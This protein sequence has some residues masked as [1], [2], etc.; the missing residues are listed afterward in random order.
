[1]SGKGLKAVA[2][3][4]TSSKTNVGPDK[5][6]DKRQLAAINRYAKR[7]GYEI[8]DIFYDAAVSGADPINERPAFAHM[9]ERLLGNGARTIIVESPDRFARDLIQQ[10]LGH[11][12]LKARGIALIAASSPQHFLE[13]T[14]TAVLIRQVLGGVAEFEKTTLV[15]KLKAARDRKR[16]ATGKCGGRKTHL[17]RRPDVV[18]LAKSLA[19]KKSKGGQLSLR[20]ISA[21]RAPSS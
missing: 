12:L 13:D 20:A 7:A 21:D 17:E 19:R 15:A 3:L 9:L 10:L 18:I 1:M 5:D 8:V 4:R 16:K 11:D 6:S 14:P 2:Y